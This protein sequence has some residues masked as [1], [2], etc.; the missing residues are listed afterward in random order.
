MALSFFLFYFFGLGGSNGD[1]IGHMEEVEKIGGANTYI[2]TCCKKIETPLLQTLK[3]ILKLYCRLSC[4]NLK[5][6]ALSH[7]GSYKQHMK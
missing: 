1:M 3:N 2:F 6:A 5:H 7:A 4:F